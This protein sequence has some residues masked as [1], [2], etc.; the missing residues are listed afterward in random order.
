DRLRLP[1]AVGGPGPA[2]PGLRAGRRRV[3]RPARLR[4]VEGEAAAAAAVAGRGRRAVLRA[5][6]GRAERHHD[7]LPA[8]LAAAA[9]ADLRLHRPR[10]ALHRRRAGRAADGRDPGR[11]GAALPGAL[12]RRAALTLSRSPPVPPPL[13][14]PARGAP[15]P[16]PRGPGCGGPRPRARRR[17]PPRCAAPPNGARPLPLPAPPLSPRPLLPAHRTEGSEP[18][19]PRPIGS[20]APPPWGR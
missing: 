15:R 20:R 8:G 11:A 5:V 1:V 6:H 2:G 10:G 3:G 4:A 13:P 19:C 14:P 7:A 17:V 9:G 18:P 12:P 16:G